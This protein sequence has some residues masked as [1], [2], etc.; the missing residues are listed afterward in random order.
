[1]SVYV[2]VCGHTHEPISP[3][4]I[5]LVEEN[6]KNQKRRKNN[7]Q[8]CAKSKYDEEENEIDFAFLS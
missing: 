6:K 2:I 7:K 4:K 5:S 1:M 3:N 8:R